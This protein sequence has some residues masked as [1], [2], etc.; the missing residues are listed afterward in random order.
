MNK[1]ESDQKF[2]NQFLSE[3]EVSL[4]ERDQPNMEKGQSKMEEIL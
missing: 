4:L 2:S 1:K 3:E